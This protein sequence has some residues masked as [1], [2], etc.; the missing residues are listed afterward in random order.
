MHSK[1][2]NSQLHVTNP[3]KS[4]SPT[5]YEY[6]RIIEFRLHGWLV[7]EIGSYSSI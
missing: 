6:K 3:I 4:F 7:N 2:D 5:N 1:P